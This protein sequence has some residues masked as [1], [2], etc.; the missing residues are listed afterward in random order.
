MAA[1]ADRARCAHPLPLPM[2]LHHGEALAFLQTLP[3]ASVDAVITD[4]PYSSGGFTR[5]DRLMDVRSKYINHDVDAVA[6]ASFSGDTRDQRG[7][8]YWVAV[9]LGECLRIVKP[10]G[11]V[12]LFTD[13]RQLPT[14]ADSLQAGGWVWRGVVPWHKP[15]ARPIRGRFS[16]SCEYI[17]WGTRG[18]RP[19]DA[20]GP[21][22]LPG[23]FSMG[24]PT[25][26]QREHLTAKPLPLMRELVRIVPNGGV[27]LDPFMGSGTTGVAAVLEGR[28]FV[29]SELTRHYYEVAERRITS[30][31]LGYRDGG[32]QLVLGD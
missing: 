4:P 28:D 22:A 14:T 23:F 3:D 27:V 6:H 11:A 24:T 31:V 30:T 8:W 1:E 2:R 20:L 16:N 29:G 21:V 17:V 10:S 12:A 25:G 13:W 15:S 32:A 7:Y 9:W 26:E 5:G 18:G 19:L